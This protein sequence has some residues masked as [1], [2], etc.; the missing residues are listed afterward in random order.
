MIGYNVQGSFGRFERSNPITGR[1]LH[2]SRVVW[3]YDPIH[4]DL[5]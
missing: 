3:Q 5:A 2:N 4:D 1:I